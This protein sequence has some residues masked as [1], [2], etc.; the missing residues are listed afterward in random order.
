MKYSSN[1]MQ[2]PIGSQYL[3]GVGTKSSHPY[4]LRRQWTV[5]G[6][7]SNTLGPTYI[8]RLRFVSSA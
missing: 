7:A 6:R 4:I 5:I 2:E 1:L 8:Q 3:P